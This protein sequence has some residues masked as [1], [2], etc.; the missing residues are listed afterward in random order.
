MAKKIACA[1][2]FVF[3]IAAAFST[4]ATHAADG[5]YPAKPIRMIVPFAP[6][7]SADAL[8]RTIQPALSEG[9]GQ[10]LVIDNRPGAAG[11]IVSMLVGPDR[12][13]TAMNGALLPINSLPDLRA[14]VQ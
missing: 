2:S 5:A 8:A 12:D 11:V 3:F 7:G 9:L 13:L 1:L 14:E 6:A 4:A 10:T